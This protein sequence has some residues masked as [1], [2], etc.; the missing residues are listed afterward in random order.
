MGWSKTNIVP[1]HSQGLKGN[2]FRRNPGYDVS[3]LRYRVFASR[4]WLKARGFSVDSWYK[5]KGAP[6]KR[7]NKR[8]QSKPR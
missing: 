3:K 1:G 8:G 5:P 2:K 7:G 4:E 6:T